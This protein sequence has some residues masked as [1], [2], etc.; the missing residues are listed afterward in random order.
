MQY[1]LDTNAFI[2]FIEGNPRLGKTSTEIVKDP[3]NKIFYSLISIWEIILKQS[4]GKLKVPQDIKKAVDYSRFEQ[5]D[6]KL[7]HVLTVKKLKPIH[8]D[9]F[10]RM[11][12]AQAKSENLTIITSDSK[13]IKYNVK[14]LKV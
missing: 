6:L 13:I 4:K 8:K 10:D 3:E 14:T 2:W 12:I 9:P 7:N 5:I 1:L 11:L